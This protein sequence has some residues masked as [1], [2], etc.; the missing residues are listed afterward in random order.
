MISLIKKKLL[1]LEELDK[2]PARVPIIS[3]SISDYSVRLRQS[4]RSML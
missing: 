1:K 3:S 4:I 2:S